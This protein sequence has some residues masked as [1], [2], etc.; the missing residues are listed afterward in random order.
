MAK[1]KQ[2]RDPE[3][4]PDASDKR[5]QKDDDDSGSDED[6]DMVNVD[7]E[8]FDPQ[9]AV[10]FHGLKNLL[11]Q[12]LDVDSQ[13]F[14]LSELADIILSQPLLGST[15]KV[16][17]NETDPYAFLTVLNLETYKDKKVIQDLTTYLTKKSQPTIPSLAPLLASTSTAQI[18]LI[19]TE[20]FINMPHEI[21]PP[22]YTM[23]LEEIQWAVE[24]KEPYTFT[25]YLVLSKCYSEIASQLPSHDTAPSK[26][27]SKKADGGE[28]TFYFHPE[29]EVLHKHAVGYTSFEYDTPVDEGASDSKRAFQELG[30]R[31]KG[32]MVLIEAG[33]FEG[34]VE[35]VKGFLS[36]Q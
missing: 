33:N 14:N 24:E 34:A 10:D 26:K 17:G 23:L 35:A 6:M 25:H 29:D 36:G 7:F 32:H 22:M 19:L 27:R 3:E 1:R 9:P 16:D 12:L 2:E 4:L 21:V 28:E 31:P 15:V 11:R 13:L 5:K 8:W 30:V 18:G 20:R